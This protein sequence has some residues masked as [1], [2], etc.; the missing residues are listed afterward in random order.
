VGH[1]ISCHPDIDLISF[2]GSTR[3]GIQIAKAAADTVKRVHQE[4]GGK[5]ANIIL[6]DADLSVAVPDGVRRAFINSGQSCIAPTRMLIQRDQMDAALR[7]AKETAEAMTVGEPTAATTRLGPLA[8]A[9]QYAR[10][11]DMIG[12]GI[13]EEATLLC[14]GLGR[15]EGLRGGYYARPTIFGG[16]TRDMRIAKEE[17]FGPV[18]S[19]MAYEDE[20]DAVELANATVYGLAAYVFSSDRVRAH[21]VAKRLRAGRV[22]VNG[23]PTDVIAPFGGYKQSGNGREAGVFGLEEFLEVKAVLG[24]ESQ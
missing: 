20:E 3:A 7:I 6:P 9:A 16:V 13:A 19:I 10:V 11:Q 14:G 21:E 4:L 15:P 5:S 23:A 12:L 2:T 8:N 17:I 24:Y 1:A 18:L 22:F